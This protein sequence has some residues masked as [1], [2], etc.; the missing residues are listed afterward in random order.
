M[1]YLGEVCRPIVLEKKLL[2]RAASIT[3]S[4]AMKGRRAPS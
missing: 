4:I 1:G 3:G 2:E